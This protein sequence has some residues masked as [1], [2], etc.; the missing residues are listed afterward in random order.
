MDLLDLER[1]KEYQS[2]LRAVA[3]AVREKRIRAKKTVEDIAYEA[4][5]HNSTSFYSSAENFTNGKH[6]SVK[7]LFL[8][9]EYLD[10]DISEFFTQEGS[11]YA[12]IE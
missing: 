6:F 1:E 3:K 5:Q 10:C 7:H 9:S 8:I 2:F 12:P 4:L 11:S